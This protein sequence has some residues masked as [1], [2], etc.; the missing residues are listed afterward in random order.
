LSDLC[1]LYVDRQHKAQFVCATRSKPRIEE[2]EEE[3]AVPR[4]LVRSLQAA[5]VRSVAL[6]LREIST[7]RKNCE[8]LR[9]KPKV[10]TQRATASACSS[11][12]WIV[13]ASL[14]RGASPS[15]L[16]VAPTSAERAAVAKAREAT[17]NY[18]ASLL[19]DLSSDKDA[20]KICGEHNLE[21]E[22]FDFVPEWFLARLEAKLALQRDLAHT[23]MLVSHHVSHVHALREAAD[24][25]TDDAPTTTQ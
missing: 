21:S 14:E 24:T 9:R 11:I 3:G 13:Q 16:L 22:A 19:G 2:E 1:V 6:L 18:V 10:C 5:T 20:W 7:D 4:S 8:T 25:A 23:Q 12:I 15:R 17:R